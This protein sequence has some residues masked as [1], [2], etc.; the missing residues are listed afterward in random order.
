[1]QLT[2]HGQDV[3]KPR[4]KHAARTEA[5][6]LKLLAA[7]Q[8]V[9]TRDGYANARLE[10]I[11]VE[12]GY[13]RGAI[14]AHYKSK[15]DLFLALIE[16]RVQATRAE[17]E[18]M[19]ESR[20]TPEERLAGMRAMLIKKAADP[21]WAMLVLEFKLFA[22]RQPKLKARLQRTIAMLHA[23]PRPDSLSPLFGELKPREIRAIHRRLALLGSILTAAVLES[24]FRPELLSGK[25]LDA[26]LGEIFEALVRK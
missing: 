23:L 6:Q 14:Y 18:R 26:A 13:T 21:S 17:F 3:A 8:D 20:S 12:A 9:F 16:Q 11:A 5:T 10:Q 2:S 1:M 15:E 22:L 24:H 7:A 4:S 25:D 19:I